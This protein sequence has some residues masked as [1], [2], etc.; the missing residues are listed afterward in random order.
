M[1]DKRFGEETIEFFRTIPKA[2][3]PHAYHELKLRGFRNCTKYFLSIVLIA[4]LIMAVAALPKVIYLSK[5]IDNQ[6]AK[7]DKF[8]IQF[9]VELSSPVVLTEKEPMVV[10]ADKNTPIADIN[11]TKVLITEDKLYFKESFTKVT[12]I[13]YKE[14]LN[15]L[16]KKDSIRKIIV[17]G[18]YLMVPTVIFLMYI[19]SLLKY[20]AIILATSVL[21]FLIARLLRY[22]ITA[23][24]AL[25]CSVYASTAM[26]LFEIVAIPFQ[27]GSYLL[28]IPVYAGITIA[29]VP[30]AVFLTIYI[31]AIILISGRFVVVG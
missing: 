28:T 26:I 23:K 17:I 5:Y 15:V 19:V 27:I 1:G 22:E 20:A 29:I 4:Y 11:Y 3:Y 10:L 18:F 7:F 14:Y 9:D 6:F 24:E 21:G 2:I 12:E 13:N 31:I 16:G 30:F 8:N 25:V